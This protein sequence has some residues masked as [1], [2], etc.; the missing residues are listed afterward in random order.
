MRSYA[1][2]LCPIK[3]S[4]MALA[5][6]ASQMLVCPVSMMCWEMCPPYSP[7]VARARCV[8][9][10]MDILSSVCSV[11]HLVDASTQRT[12]APWRASER[13]ASAQS[14]LRPTPP[15]APPNAA[16]MGRSDNSWGPSRFMCRLGRMGQQGA[17]QSMQSN[18]LCHRLGFR[19]T[20]LA[21]GWGRVRLCSG[22]KSTLASKR[23]T[24]C[25]HDT[26]QPSVSLC[27]GYLDAFVYFLMIPCLTK[28]GKDCAKVD[29]SG[30]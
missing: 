3:G 2:R 5:N 9:G 21:R 27:T 22:Q 6:A 29:L 23:A 18:E 28:E 16:M 17:G 20:L 10:G 12:R 11:G 7:R 13:A 1:S 30:P 14:V 8:L 4:L 26:S 24:L 19:A 15:F 25:R